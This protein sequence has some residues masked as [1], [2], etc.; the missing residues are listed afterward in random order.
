MRM[1]GGRT[2]KKIGLIAGRRF[3]I[4]S[5]GARLLGIRARPFILGPSRVGVKKGKGTFWDRS[6]GAW[7]SPIVLSYYYSSSLLFSH[8][9]GRTTLPSRF[10][11][12]KF[13]LSVHPPTLFVH[14]KYCSIIDTCWLLL[15]GTTSLGLEAKMC[16]EGLCWS[17]QK[18]V[19]RV[20]AATGPD[21]PTRD[22]FSDCL[23]YVVL[24]K[25][26]RGFFTI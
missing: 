3:W 1:A 6:S 4:F 7:E 21:F 15:S 13:F 23:L 2:R 10:L 8:F 24:D 25:S 20:A 19:L 16:P 5:S 11:N 18:R 12:S 22:T 14:V 9:V 26:L 17:K